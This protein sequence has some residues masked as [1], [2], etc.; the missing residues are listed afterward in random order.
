MTT[1]RFHMFSTGNAA[2]CTLMAQSVYNSSVANS[3]TIQIE[4]GKKS[5]LPPLALKSREADND[6]YS[7]VSQFPLL[8]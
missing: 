1:G 3:T 8:P 6:T 5:A 4:N 7:P 2:G